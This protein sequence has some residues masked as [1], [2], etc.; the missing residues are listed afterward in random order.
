[1]C[2]R[3]VIWIDSVRGIAISL[4]VYGHVIGGYTGNYSSIEYQNFVTCGLKIIYSFHMPLF[5]MISG[6]VYA[7]GKNVL[8]IKQYRNFISKKAR[9]LLIPYY[10]CSV[11]QILIKL[12]LQGKISSVLSWK[13]I[14]LL[15]IK[16]VDQY[17]YIYVL[18]FMFCIQ[19]SLEM[20][21]KDSLA[22]AFIMLLV[23]KGLSLYG[24]GKNQCV[25][26][27]ANKN[28]IILLVFLYWYYPSQK[29]PSLFQKAL[30]ALLNSILL[31]HA[32][33]VKL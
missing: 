15:P 33:I 6:Y 14:F 18:F 10:V 25:V 2:E 27:C 29:E 16:P 20:N 9:Q 5:F 28:I 12:P 24:G 13:D 1:M 4:V 8:N 3:R 7:L 21:H 23:G 26:R 32:T 22:L 19:P 11:V 30:R 17:W 31:T